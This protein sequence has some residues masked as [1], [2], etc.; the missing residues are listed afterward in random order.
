MDYKVSYHKDDELKNY[1]DNLFSILNEERALLKRYKFSLF[2]NIKEIIVNNNQN[3]NFEIV[4]NKYKDIE[5]KYVNVLKELLEK[6]NTWQFKIYKLEN[7]YIFQNMRDYRKLFNKEYVKYIKKLKL[8]NG[9]EY[10]LNDILEIVRL[11][12]RGV[13]W[14][15]IIWENISIHT[16]Y[17]YC[18]HI[19]GI[20]IDKEFIENKL[21]D[22]IIINGASI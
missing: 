2:S 15:E 14:C 20:E 8:K 10:M 9:K 5:N 11:C 13:M 22:G 16:G 3:N 6:N 19:K 21:R 1:A 4:L 12:L 18:M 17:G 7:R